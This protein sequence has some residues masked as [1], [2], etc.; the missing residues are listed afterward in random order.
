MKGAILDMQHQCLRL[1]SI[2]KN[3]THKPNTKKTEW[4]IWEDIAETLVMI[5]SPGKQLEH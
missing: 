3:E 2:E 1:P 4:V 5:E